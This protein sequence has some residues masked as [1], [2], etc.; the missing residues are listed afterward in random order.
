M[1]ISLIRSKR[2]DHLII[3]ND[4]LRTQQF[5]LLQQQQQ[6]HF[7]K[8]PTPPLLPVNLNSED[9]HLIIKAPDITPEIY[10]LLCDYGNVNSSSTTSSDIIIHQSNIRIPAF[11]ITYAIVSPLPLLLDLTTSVIPYF[12]FLLP[13]ITTTT[14]TPKE[15]ED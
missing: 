12:N 5:L 2:Y 1:G 14:I 13:P 10:H 9:R 7:L 3:T 15:K 4:I 11:L 6:Q 8:E